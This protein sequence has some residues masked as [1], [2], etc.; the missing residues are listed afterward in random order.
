MK[1][2]S[3]KADRSFWARNL[4]FFSLFAA[5]FRFRLLSTVAA[6][7]NGVANK[8]VSYF[9]TCAPCT[10]VRPYL[11]IYIFL[12]RFDHVDCVRPCGIIIIYIF[13]FYFFRFIFHFFLPRI[14]VKV[15]PKSYYPR[16]TR[17]NFQ[18]LNGL[19]QSTSHKYFRFFLGSPPDNMYIYM[20]DFR[21]ILIHTE[22]CQRILV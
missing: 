19:M 9:R 16:W 18:L 17:S 20:N 22:R 8:N 3:S 11:W 21:F 15:K 13:Y 4:C 14:K 12:G 10:S 5:G 6:S 1:E 2:R 7:S